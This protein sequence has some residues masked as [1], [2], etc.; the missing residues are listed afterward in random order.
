MKI[1]LAK[2]QGSNI[3]IYVERNDGNR[4]YLSSWLGKTLISFTETTLIAQDI[5]KKSPPRMWAVKG[6]RLEITE[7]RV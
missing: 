4:T 5:K 1:L 7:I 3:Q 2:Q 6:D